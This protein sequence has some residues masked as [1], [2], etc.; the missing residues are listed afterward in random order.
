M[1]G[2]RG[3]RE[4]R[5]RRVKRPVAV[6]RPRCLEADKVGAIGVEGATPQRRPEL[7]QLTLK[8]RRSVDPKSDSQMELMQLCVEQASVLNFPELG[9]LPL[10]TRR[11]VDPGIRPRIG[12]GATLICAHANM[13]GRDDADRRNSTLGFTSA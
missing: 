12:V 7:V 9:Q 8:T 13:T 2:H 3:V 10:E 11:T 5:P 1:P 6:E 4:R